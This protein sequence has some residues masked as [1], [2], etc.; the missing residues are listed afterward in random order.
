MDFRPLFLAIFALLSAL[1]IA[2]WND[3]LPPRPL[4]PEVE[5]TWFG[6]GE[7]VKE[8]IEVKPFKIDFKPKV[9]HIFIREIL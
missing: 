8:S 1:F 6:P 3:V 5:K 2:V 7:R 9:I 4:K